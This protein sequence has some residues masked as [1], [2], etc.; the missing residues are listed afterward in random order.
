MRRKPYWLVPLLVVLV[1]LSQAD[2]NPNSEQSEILTGAAWALGF[3][4]LA[5]V[6]MYVYHAEDTHPSVSTGDSEA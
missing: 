5:M 3:V 1:A 2:V 6:V 4:V